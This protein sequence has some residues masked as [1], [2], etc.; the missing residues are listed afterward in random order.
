MR[1]VQPEVF[2]VARPAIDY[3]QL[4]AYLREVGGEQWLERLDRGELD[5]AQNLAEFAGK[6]CYRAWEPGLNPNVSKVRNDHAA[7]LANILKSAHGS[8]LEHASFTFVLHNISRV[9][10][11]ELVRHRP[12]TAVSQESLRF[13][14]L[15]DIP[16]WFPDWAREDPELMKRAT[17]LLDQMEELQRWMAGHFG[18]DDAGVP[19]HEK[20][21]KTSFMRRLAPGRGGHRD[22]LDGQHPDAAAHHRGAHRSRRGGGDPAGLRQDRRADAGRGAAAVRRLRGPGRRLDAA[23]PEGLSG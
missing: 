15:D 3:E 6:L 4:A 20:K 18:L 23:V 5:D 14:R 10:S 12:G 21:H 1:P 19:F 16:F 9:F 22:G 7:Y 17:A 11:H 8:V 2:L 13:V